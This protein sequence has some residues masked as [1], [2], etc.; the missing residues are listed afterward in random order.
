VNAARRALAFALG[1]VLAGA[2][3]AAVGCGYSTQRLSDTVCAGRTISILPFKNA[4]FYRDAELRLTQQ[5]A[6]E[7]RAR[8]SYALTTADRAD[9]VMSGTLYFNQS[10]VAQ[11][12]SDDPIVKGTYATADVRLT[13]RRT[14]RVVKQYGAFAT[15]E[16]TPGRFGESLEGSGMDEVLR[17][18]AVRVVDGLE[19]GF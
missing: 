12:T 9:V 18:L 5:V 1:L 13:D 16:F 15:D 10:I 14:G 7:V 3:G 17:R 4:T 8:T 19:R 6:E 2:A 11:R